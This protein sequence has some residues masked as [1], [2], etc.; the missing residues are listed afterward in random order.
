MGDQVIAGRY[1]LDERLGGGETA[2]V[3]AATDLELDRKVAV[4][5]L[6]READ[7]RRFRR[8]AHAVG[9]L[10]HPNIATLYDYG[11]A[12]ERPF[13]A[14]EF[15]PAGRSRSGSPAGRCPTR[16]PTEPPGTLPPGSP[17]PTRTGS[18]TAI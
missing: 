1:R 5:L 14:F 17:S 18:S 3:W 16:R 12:G 7:P 13:M 8:E 15:L 11:E 9:A 6:A 10:A 2:E 4:K